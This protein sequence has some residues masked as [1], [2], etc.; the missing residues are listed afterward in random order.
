LGPVLASA[1]PD[2]T[3]RWREG[4]RLDQLFEDQCDRLLEQGRG[5][6]LAVDADGIVLTYSDLDRRANQLA[7]HLLGCGAR[8][9][10]RI[11]LLFD[12]PSSAYTA[13]LAVLKIG[14]AYVPLDPGFP[15]DRLKYI[16]EDAD[17]AVVLSLSHLKDLLPE[18][19]ALTIC[20][21]HVRAH[22]NPDRLDQALIGGTKD[23]LAYI[24]YTSGS[25]GSPKGVAI[26]HASIC[27]FVRV[28]SDLYGIESTDR[29]YQGMTIAFDF[30]VEEIWV[31][32]LAGATLVPKPGDPSLLGI[33]LASYLVEK[34]ITALCC[35]PTLL[36][37]IDEDLPG[38]RFLPVSGEVCPRDLV[39]RWHSPGRRFLNVYGPTEATVTATWAVVDPARPVSLGVP[40]PTYSAVILDPVRNRALPPGETGEIGLAGV[41]LAR[42]YV[43]RPDLTARAFIPDFLGI[44]N[45]PSGR[46]YRTGDLGRINSE[47]E[48]E[49][50]GRID[51]Q[52]KI[53]GY[54]IELTE[55]ES[56]LLQFPGIAQA[57]VG[58]FE[59][60]PGLVELA[61]YYTLRHDAASVEAHDI[62]QMLRTRLPGYMVPAYFE[63]LESIPMMASG[64]A[65]RKRLQPPS[66][67]V[68]LAGSGSYTA[69][70]TAIE[71]YLAEQL[72]AVLGLDRVSTDAHFFNDLGSNSLLMAHFCARVRRATDL[73]PAAMQDIYQHP[74][75]RQLAAVLTAVQPEAVTGPAVPAANLMTDAPVAPANTLQYVVC[76]AIQLAVFLGYTMY[77]SFLLVIGFEWTSGGND[78]LDMWLRS[79]GSGAAMFLTLSV[80]PIIVK[81]ILVG[82]WKQGQIRIWSLAYVRFW[83]VKILTRANPLVLFAG[84]PLYVLYLRLLGAKIGKGVVIFSRKVPVC[85]DL[86]TVGD[87]TVIHKNSVF[88]CCRARSGVIE[89]GPVTLG[90]MCLSRRKPLSTSVLQWETTPSWD[91]PRHCRHRNLYPRDRS[92]T[93]PQQP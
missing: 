92:G 49:Y 53:R 20:L 37:T 80:T 66:G 9:G 55:I 30:S 48:I 36:A 31:S 87:G 24:I 64:K 16:V 88:L 43:N 18:V 21:D 3:V 35:V 4:E 15:P 26:E 57:V 39:T 76:G 32:W 81:W 25:A 74:T 5:G 33:E 89:T 77:G 85:T 14:A 47:G 73:T 51:T 58:T 62:Y 38:L 91:T 45:N 19:A 1:A 71:A 44:G 82:R 75:I 7:R 22:E 61:A 72:G 67:R 10:D 29:V 41:G 46:I 52:V 42:G 6:H 63:Q 83:F 27:N 34:R 78:P 50:L 79:V 59:P 11:A 17:V 56:F 93:V 8:P 69:P 84:S 68:S 65:D 2:L 12:Q 86:L 60:E 23:E 13:M 70:V 54:R 28:A 90:K 40:L